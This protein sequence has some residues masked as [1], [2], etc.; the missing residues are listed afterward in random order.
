LRRPLLARDEI[1]FDERSFNRAVGIA[2]VRIVADAK[3]R[4]VLKNDAPRAF[5]LDRQQFEWIFEPADFKFLP[6]ERAGLDG[7]AVVIRH[8]LVLLIAAADPD[9]FVRKCN[10]AGF[11]AGRDQIMRPA[12]DRDVEFGTGKARACDNRFEIA[13][14]KSFP[15]AQARN[16]NGLK[17]LFEEGASGISI[18]RPQAEGIAADIPQCAIALSAVVNA[19]YFA[20][21]LAA[22][23]IGRE[24]GE[25]IIGP[26]AR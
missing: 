2:V 1:A 14:H 13:G 25:V 12:V 8:E 21:G 10:C 9:P 26:P 3:R 24:G 7:A 6:I 16:P 11:V 20:Q 23:L 17:V 5:N 22:G 19:T 18:P 4:A 15:L